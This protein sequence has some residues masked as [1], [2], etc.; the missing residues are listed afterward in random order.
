MSHWDKHF[1]PCWSP[2]PAR[3]GRKEGSSWP[4]ERQLIKFSCFHYL[5]DLLIVVNYSI[6][7]PTLS[8]TGMATYK[9]KIRSSY[10][11]YPLLNLTLFFV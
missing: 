5:A 4:K 2:W 3:T 6:C 10:Q 7:F 1:W 11:N 9:V 8:K